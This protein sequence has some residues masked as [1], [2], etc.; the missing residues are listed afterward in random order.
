MNPFQVR[1]DTERHVKNVD[2]DNPFLNDHS[3]ASESEDDD[4]EESIYDM[5]ASQDYNFLRSSR[6]R[7]D[8]DSNMLYD[9][10]SSNVQV[11]PLIVDMMEDH[12]GLPGDLSR[13]KG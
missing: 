4:K 2:S 5:N 13:L 1:G 6:K 7:T 9:D 10:T 12:F 3:E 11:E 8:S